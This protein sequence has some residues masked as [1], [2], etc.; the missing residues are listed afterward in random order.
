VVSPHPDDET[1]CCGGLIERARAAGAQVAVVWLTSGDA[2]QLDAGMVERRLH[3]GV[4][5]MREL[6]VRRM[7]EARE[8][9]T[10]LGVPV[11][12]QFFLGFPDRGLLPLLLDHFY[13][14]YTST[15]TQLDRV[16]Y[17]GTLAPGASY[18]G[19]ELLR[20]LERLL[21][22]VQPTYVLAPSPLD[23]HPDH[24]AAGDLV[25]RALGERRQLDRIRYWIVHGGIGWPAPRGLHAERALSPPRR[26]RALLWQSVS[27]S[28][29]QRRGKLAAL[30][31]YHTQMVGLERRYLESFVRST[32]LYALRPLPEPL[33]AAQASRALA[34]K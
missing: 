14:R 9:A 3:P 31:A 21:D 8:A 20:Q 6:G 30:G 7:Q 12:S 32:E 33:A 18:E 2:F 5:G 25:I 28:E 27:L 34:K 4:A 23:T 26:A 13:V 16:S 11:E 17:P 19:G 1:L 10:A 22:Q 24:R 15:F 29:P